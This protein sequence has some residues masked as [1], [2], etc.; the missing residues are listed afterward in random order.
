[1][2]ER[3]PD[4]GDEFATTT[5]TAGLGQPTSAGAAPSGTGDAGAAAAAVVDQVQEVAGQVQE[6]AGRLL[7]QARQQLTT[8][9][10]SQKD[11][12]ASG[13]E[14]VV[15]VLRQTGQQVR[16]QDQGAVAQYVEGAADQL[17]RFS[18]QLRTQDVSQ[19]VDATE[20][21]AR[22][23][24][25]LFVGGALAAGFLATRFLLS[26][27]PQQGAGTGYSPDAAGGVSPYAT[28]IYA[29]GYP[30]TMAGAG[31]GYGGVA[32]TGS[33]SGLSE[34]MQEARLSGAPLTPADYA[35]GSEE[36]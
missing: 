10:T 15:Q 30:G 16:E 24:P 23:Q 18:G 32:D 2:A 31:L 6:Q 35:P 26:S 11:R 29:S 20:R 34:A 33:A 13:L 22:R 27:R 25:A 36:R 28:D 1:M 7:D 9:V 19:L 14:T 17:E 3:E 5:P 12:A 21:F 8:Q 4:A